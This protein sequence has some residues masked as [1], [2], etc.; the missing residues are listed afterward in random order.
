[1]QALPA[2]HLATADVAR[3][4]L[5]VLNPRAFTLIICSIAAGGVWGGITGIALDVP[6]Y[7]FGF[8]VGAGWGCC[9]SGVLILTVA[10]KRLAI[11]LPVWFAAT[12]AALIVALML[13]PPYS[14]LSLPIAMSTG[15]YIA[16]SIALR[17]VLQDDPSRTPDRSRCH[18]CGYPRS[19]LPIDIC[20]E[21]GQRHSPTPR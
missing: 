16:S 12:T 10:R 9:C 6:P 14:G 18:R 8:I 20:P 15:A 2:R 3:G 7:E 5:K 11:A 4:T 17:V 19:G 21:C 1:M 13:T